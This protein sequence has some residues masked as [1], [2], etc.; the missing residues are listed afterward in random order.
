MGFKLNFGIFY[1]L[2]LLASFNA[3]ASA[4]LVGACVSDP[5]L[6]SS[7][8]PLVIIPQFYFSGALVAVPLI[9]AWIQWLQYVISLRWLVGLTLVYEYDT[10]SADSAP[11]CEAA[12]EANGLNPDD[13]WWYWII[14]VCL[15]V[16]FKIAS[17]GLLQ[18]NVGQ[19]QGR[20]G[21]TAESKPSA[22]G[23]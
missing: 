11:Y 12:L 20:I 15:F 2:N 21:K 9:P 4:S 1:V 3:T 22:T 8:F 17:V 23:S 13:R 6:A 16:F 5:A 19:V 10:C 7:M 14:V 18:W